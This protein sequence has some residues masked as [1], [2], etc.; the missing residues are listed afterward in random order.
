[1]VGMVLE[2][3]PDETDTA[4][5]YDAG[6]TPRSAAETVLKDQGMEDIL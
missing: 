4:A 3:M 1:M 5:L 6:V 2:D